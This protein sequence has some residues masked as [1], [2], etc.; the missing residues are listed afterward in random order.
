M[1]KNNK[2]ITLIALVV[3]IVIILILA[4]AML[5]IVVN[6]GI[7]NQAKYATNKYNN[8]VDEENNTLKELYS[9]LKIASSG[10]LENVDMTTLK[11]VILDSTYP[12]GSIYL[13]TDNRNPS[14]TLGGTWEKYAEGKTIIGE[15]TNTENSETYTFTI[16]QQQD[17]TDANK[18]PTGEYKHQLSVAEMPSHNHS[19]NNKYSIYYWKGGGGAGTQGSTGWY[20]GSPSTSIGINNTGGDASH[21]NIQPYVT[22]YMWKRIS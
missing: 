16:D 10:S 19:I 21:N 20:S 8:S 22:T 5:G 4:G 1:K 14:E 15:G 13:T 12:V 3:T 9:Q 17:E 18:N 7:F 11:Q 2:A 6:G